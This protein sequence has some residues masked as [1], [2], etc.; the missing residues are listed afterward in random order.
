MYTIKNNIKDELIIN[1]SKFITYIYKVNTL[2][3][4]NDILSN[5]KKEYKDATHI[6]YAYILDNQER[7]NDDN[8]PTGTAGMPILE[9]LKKNNLNYVVCFV[10]RYFGGI[11]LGSGGLIR[12]Y[13][14]SCSSCLKLTNIKKLEKLFKI[15]LTIS[16]SD[17]KL[18]NNL[19]NDNNIITKTYENDIN[20]LLLV[21]EDIL[22]KINSYNLKYKIIDDNYF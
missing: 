17:N 18:L 10:I 14:N 5:L 21:N 9:V 16:Y 22:N 20:Y 6:C 13:S 19:I 2:D 3:E 7:F 8:E 4:V 12:A 15:S 11:K 1:K